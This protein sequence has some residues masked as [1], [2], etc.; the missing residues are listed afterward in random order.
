MWAVGLASVVLVSGGALDIWR[1]KDSGL[2]DHLVAASAAACIPT[3][4]V[5]MRAGFDPSILAQLSGINVYITFAGFA[6]VYV[7]I[8]AIVSIYQRRQDADT[9]T[10]SLDKT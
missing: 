8:K 9:K 6:L 7:S 1:R 10:G 3:G 5:L 2:G 4:L